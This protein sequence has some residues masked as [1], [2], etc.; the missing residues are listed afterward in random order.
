ME[1][2]PEGA[3]NK[4]IRKRTE[5][6]ERYLRCEVLRHKLGMPRFGAFSVELAGN[7]VYSNFC[8]LRDIRGVRATSK[9]ALNRASKF[10]SS[11]QLAQM[12]KL[13]TEAACNQ[14]HCGELGLPEPVDSSFCLVDSTCLEANIHFPMDWVLLKDVAMTLLKAVKLIRCK[15]RL[16]NRMQQGPGELARQMN[17]LC[18]EMTFSNRRKD[19]RKLRKNVLRRMK[20]L[21]RRVGRHAKVHRDLLEQYWGQTQWS[22]KQAANI[23]ARVDGAL[24]LLPKVAR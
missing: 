3:S 8:G 22:K 23:L 15:G 18:K 4:V 20:A 21:L 16:L 12:F 1:A 11:G 19:G 17:N 9:S 13:L 5:T 10:F 7:E 24:G 14:D 6:A 2:L